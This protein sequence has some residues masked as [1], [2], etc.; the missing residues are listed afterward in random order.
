MK[1]K[2][3]KKGIFGSI[4]KII[5]IIVILVVLGIAGLIGAIKI[6]P[7]YKNN[8]IT[9]RTNLVI[10]FSNVTGRMKNKIILEND[11]VYVSF[12]DVMNYYDYNLYY[13]NK[14]N[15]IITSTDDKLAALKVDENSIEVNG[16]KRTIKGA[17]K[18]V[19]NVYYLPISEMEDIYNIKVTKSDNKVVI[20]SIDKKS[21][22]G[23]ASKNIKLKSKAKDL[24]RTVE[25][26]SAG[27]L[28][29]I[30]EVDENSLPQGWV[31]VRTKNGNLG[32][33]KEK[34]IKDIKVERE[35]KKKAKIM[36]EKVSLAWDYF[37]E[38]AKAPDNTGKTYDGVNVVS[39]S[40]FYLSIK[41]MQKSGAKQI[42][43]K[44]QAKVKENVGNSG[45]AYIKWAKQN[46]YKLWPKF[47]NE[48]LT[49][50]IDEFS[51][52][53]ND[54]ELRKSMIEDLVSYVKEY[55]LDGINLDF[56]YMYEK[57]KDAFSRFV[58]ELAPR[59][60][61]VNACLSVDVTAPDGGSNW[62]LCY[63]RN[64]IGEVADY[65]VFMGYDQYGANT[66]GT[67]SGYNWVENTINKLL[68]YEEIPSEKIILGLPFYTKLWKTKNEQTID[69]TVV[70][71]RDISNEIV[72]GV[73]KE[74]IEDFKQYYIQ[75]ERG[76]YVY[77]LWIEDEE[78]FESKLQLVN[79]YNL[80][81]AAYW[82]KGFESN[83][84]WEIVKH[85]LD[86]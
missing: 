8:E 76:G 65:V 66:I 15:Q 72:K 83:K 82:R 1:E 26:I 54:Y 4:L 49:S 53:I 63:D 58:I 84:V 40:F 7:N 52:I 16:E 62:S 69:S 67:T 85:V 31:K 43:I 5:F 61:A 17:A 44:E 29:K 24:C 71:L 37:S 12:N 38:Y 42:D 50:T 80:A 59:L 27:D 3:A 9:D 18:S 47:S 57:D 79:E 20:E 55:E 75:Y 45:M 11:I 19:N 51:E 39:P 32:Y 48:T 25:K 70:Y 41:D 46:G 30:A 74:W 14:T 10:N 77:K 64:L 78:S 35:E 81:G 34:D 56:E 86:L 21:T 6:L 68:K 60:R 13:D 23:T 2:E 73:N 28:L 36:D 22:I 33:V